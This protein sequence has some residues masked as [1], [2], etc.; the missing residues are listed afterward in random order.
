MK[1]KTSFGELEVPKKIE[2]E[3]L[4]YNK[5]N[6][7]DECEFDDWF[8]EE[9]GNYIVEYSD[10]LCEK[11]LVEFLICWKCHNISDY[12]GYDKEFGIGFEDNGYKY[13]VSTFGWTGD[14]EQDPKNM[15]FDTLVYKEEIKVVDKNEK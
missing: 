4:K 6:P 14:L 5:E 12:G 9:Y 15:V 7:D 10:K 13:Y 11:E 1:I 3:F 8:I 2:R